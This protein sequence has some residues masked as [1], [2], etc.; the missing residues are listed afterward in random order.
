MR[1]QRQ[2]AEEQIR[3]H[4]RTQMRGV[5]GRDD[6]IRDLDTAVGQAISRSEERDAILEA[7]RELEASSLDARLLRAQNEA[8]V[9]AELEALRAQLE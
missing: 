7:A 8:E 3:A 9:D 1:R 2:H 5:S 4:L 6:L